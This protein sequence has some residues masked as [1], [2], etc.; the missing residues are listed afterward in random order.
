M[1]I[2]YAAQLQFNDILYWAI[3]ALLFDFLDGTAARILNVSSEIGKELDSLADVVSFGVAPTIV[4]FYYWQSV[5]TDGIAFCA[6]FAIALFAAFRLA[7]FNSTEQNN[8]YFRGLPTPALALGCFVLP[9]VGGS[10]LWANS[11]INN[12]YFVM[13]FSLL[14]GFMLVSNFKFFSLKLG[15]KN[16]KLNVIR[17]TYLTTCILLIVWLH[18]FGAFLCLLAYIGFSLSFQNRIN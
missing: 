5:F 15:S 7:K 4:L 12:I 10:F 17:T 2:V 6:P 1:I 14:G 18:F 8:D 9:Q 3:A 16:K 13:V 11:A